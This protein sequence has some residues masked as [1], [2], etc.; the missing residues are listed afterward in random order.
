MILLLNGTFGVGKTT[1]AGLIGG[2]LPATSVYDPEMIGFVL[3]RVLSPVRQ[4]ADYQDLQLWRRATI[5][6]AWAMRRRRHLIVPM[7]LWRRGYFAEITAGLR[8]ID[9]G[10]LCIRLTASEESIRQRIMASDDAA[11]RAWRLGHL[12]SGVRAMTDPA[13]G[14]EISTEG[15]TAADVADAVL[16]RLSA[17]RST[18]NATARPDWATGDGRGPLP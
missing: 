2:Q 3:R 9:A 16:R 1:V 12:A 18:N 6:G 14:I 17:A 7:T 10:L 4:A 15:R 11:A 8:R 13:F 5:W